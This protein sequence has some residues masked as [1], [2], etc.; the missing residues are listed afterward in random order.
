MK[1]TDIK[2]LAKEDIIDLIAN[3]WMLITAGTADKFNTMT[4]SW[5]GVG[6]LWHKPVAYLFIRPERY[7]HEFVEANDRLTISF[8][9]ESQ[10]RALQLCGSKSGR[11]INKVEAAGLH[12]VEM[13]EGVMGFDEARLT[14]VGRKLFKADMKA[15][16]FVDESLLERWYNDQPGGGFHSVYVVEIESVY[17][18]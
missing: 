7:T 2:V 3:Q 1:K 8:F 12:A 14:L 17:E 6:Y 13:P 9:P 18:K 15:E 4:A 11:D 16:D 5:G 10:R